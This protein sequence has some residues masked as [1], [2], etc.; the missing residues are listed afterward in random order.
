MP[1]ENERDEPRPGDLWRRKRD[2]LVVQITAFDRQWSDV[3]WRE[4]NGKRKG[5]VF[6]FNFKRFYEKQEN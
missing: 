6:L 4:V 1:T 2:G 3:A 5:F